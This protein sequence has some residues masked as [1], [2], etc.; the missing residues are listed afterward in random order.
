MSSQRTVPILKRVVYNI[1]EVANVASN[2]GEKGDGKWLNY[3]SVEALILLWI[4]QP[5]PISE[6][7]AGGGAQPKLRLQHLLSGLRLTLLP[8]SPWSQHRENQYQRQTNKHSVWLKSQSTPGVFNFFFFRIY[9]VHS[10]TCSVHVLSQLKFQRGK[11]ICQ[12]KRFFNCR[13]HFVII[14]SQ[15]LFLFLFQTT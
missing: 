15:S 1:I 14:E 11:V 9:I 7:V 5:R 13:V 8:W 6:A 2:Q 10:L 3:G 4:P 12:T